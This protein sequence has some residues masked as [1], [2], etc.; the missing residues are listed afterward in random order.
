M[1]NFPVI[2]PVA[3]CFGPICVYW[4][5]VAYAV[6]I[7][8]AFYL[9]CLLNKNYASNV[10]NDIFLN[11][12]VIYSVLGIV[13]GGRLGYVMFYHPL[14]FLYEPLQVLMIRNG[15]MSFHG[16]LIGATIAL[17]F[18]CK[19]CKVDFW[20]AA[21][22]VVCVAPI[23]LFLGR[24][25]NFINAELIGRVTNVSWAVIFP[26]S[27]GLPRHPSQLYEACSEGL[28]LFVF[29]LYLYTNFAFQRNKGWFSGVF[30]ICYGIMR[31]FVEWFREPEV[32]LNFFSYT[33]TIGQ[34]LSI[35]LVIVGGMLVVTRKRTMGR[36][37]QRI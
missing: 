14:W 24:I 28:L 35:P 4:Y 30:L 36:S 5:G 1:M 13:I 34:L 31:F 29:M 6:G 7:L 12:F 11:S 37:N 23:G 17:Y 9:L 25:A 15:G 2:N 19:K 10:L 16:G 21:D 27:D 32:V 22:L 26:G 18:L 8:L 20:N 3:F 33:V